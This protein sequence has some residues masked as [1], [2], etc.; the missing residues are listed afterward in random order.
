VNVGL[1][2]NFT[3][4]I[5]MN[6]SIFFDCLLNVDSSDYR[7]WNRCSPT[8]CMTHKI[9]ATIH[10]YVFKLSLRTMS[11]RALLVYVI[12][13]YKIKCDDWTP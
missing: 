1:L 8:G 3:H 6:L 13:T 4:S 12:I 10:C 7:T 2:H 11:H 9:Q 5:W